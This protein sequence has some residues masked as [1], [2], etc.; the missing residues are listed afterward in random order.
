MESV[1]MLLTGC[2]YFQVKEAFQK[3]V[4]PNLVICLNSGGRHFEV[5]TEGCA[6]HVVKLDLLSLPDL[7]P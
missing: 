3:K 6:A 7:A 1:W 5:V 2:C 4:I